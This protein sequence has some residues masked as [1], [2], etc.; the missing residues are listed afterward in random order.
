MRFPDFRLRTRLAAFLAVLAL[1][2]SFPACKT[3]PPP[4]SP[5]PVVTAP[6]VPEVEP[7]VEPKGLPYAADPRLNRLNGI[8]P[9]QLAAGGVP[10]AVVLVGHQGRIIYLQAF[11]QRAVIPQVLPMTPETVFDIASLTKVVA[12]TTA[13]M[14]LA[15]AG[16]LN[17]DKPVAAYWPA[18]G[19]NGKGGI[20]LRQLLTHSS[21]LRADLNSRASWLGYDGGMGAIVADSP[22]YPPGHGYRYSDANFIALGEVVRRVSGENLDVYCAQKIFKPLGMWHTGFRPRASKDLIAP[23]DLRWGEVHDPTAHRLGGV[24][25][26]AGVFATAEDL[27]IFCQMLLNNGSFQGGKILSPK[28]VAAMIKPHRLRGANTIR[29]LGW[30]MLSPFSKPFTLSF[31]RGSF[32]HTGYTGT[33]IWMDPNSQTFL[34]ILTNRL[35]PHGRGV[36]KSLRTYTAAAVAAAVPMGP[37]AEMAS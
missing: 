29:A 8:I 22:V 30:D 18:F 15:D 37:P 23:T 21:G 26:N 10:G 25:G 32:G 4:P 2:L 19:A 6:S 5:P 14:Q 12:T 20:T 28:A 36:V 34:I 1:I 31:P 16:R 11:G 9:S 3:A 13:I 35:H 7:A 27:A 33:S 24:A 17:L